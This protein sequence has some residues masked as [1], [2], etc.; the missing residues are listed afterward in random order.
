MFVKCISNQFMEELLIVG[1][2]Y[3]VHSVLENA[4]VLVYVNKEET[5]E[6]GKEYFSTYFNT[7]I[8]C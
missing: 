1:E 3:K 8:E 4:N 6:F 2:V 7:F 5:F